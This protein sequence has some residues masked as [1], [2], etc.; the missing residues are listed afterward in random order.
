MGIV[1]T[2]HGVDKRRPVD[3]HQ[4]VFILVSAPARRWKNSWRCAGGWCVRAQQRAPRAKLATPFAGVTPRCVYRCFS[5]LNMSQRVWRPF[6]RIGGR[7]F[8]D[9]WY[10]RRSLCQPATL[11][12]QNQPDWIA[13]VRRYCMMS[14]RHARRAAF[15][16]SRPKDP[17]ITA[18]WIERC[19]PA[20][21]WCR[22]H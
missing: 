13:V 8:A 22:N 20:T 3:G 10:R 18:R 19:L 12:A 5:P 7:A 1:P 11:S 17:E 9:V 4:P 2:L 15:Y 6:S 14:E 21:S 16:R